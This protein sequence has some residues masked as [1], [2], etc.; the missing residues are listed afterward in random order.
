MGTF[1]SV[2]AEKSARVG[3]EGYQDPFELAALLAGQV[4]HQP[5]F[6]YAHAGVRAF[7]QFFACGETFV[8]R[9]SSALE[10]S[11]KR[12]S[13]RMQMYCGNANPSGSSTVAVTSD[14]NAFATRY[15]RYPSGCSSRN[16]LISTILTYINQVDRHGV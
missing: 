1:A 16:S 3:A 10:R 6:G 13:I 15:S 4:G 11:G 12:D 2:R 8:S 5:P 9:A 14:R 7:E